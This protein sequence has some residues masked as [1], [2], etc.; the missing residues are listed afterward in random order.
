M[1]TTYRYK[2]PLFAATINLPNIGRVDCDSGGWFSAASGSAQEAALLAAGAVREDEL[3]SLDG[4]GMDGV[5]RKPETYVRSLDTPLPQTTPVASATTT[6]INTIINDADGTGNRMEWPGMH[7][8]NRQR[9]KTGTGFQLYVQTGGVLRLMRSPIGGGTANSVWTEVDRITGLDLFKA[10]ILRDPSRDHLFLVY[11]KGASNSYQIAIRTYDNQG[12]SIAAEFLVDP[13]GTG[14]TADLSSNGA[15][16]ESGCGPSG[17]VVLA[18]WQYPDPSTLRQNTTLNCYKTIQ[19]CQWDGTTWTRKPMEKFYI[20][21]RA[22]YDMLG[23]G[24]DGDTNMAYGVMQFNQGWWEATHPYYNERLPAIRTA[25]TYLFDRIGWWKHNLVTGDFAWGYVTPPLPWAV[26]PWDG[27]GSAFNQTNDAPEARFRTCTFNF[28]T[29]DW[30]V[31][32]RCNRPNPYTAGFTFTGSIT[33]NTLT[34]TTITGTPINEGTVLTAASQNTLGITGWI[35]IRVKTLGANGT[36]GTGGTGTYLL[37]TPCTIASGTISATNPSTPSTTAAATVGFRLAIF[38][39]DGRLKWDGDVL[40][41]LSYGLCN[42]WQHP[43]TGRMF[44]IYTGLGSQRSELHVFPLTQNA[45]GSVNQ[46]VKSAANTLNADNTPVGNVGM[47]QTT[48]YFGTAVKSPARNVSVPLGMTDPLYGA[49]PAEWIDAH[50]IRRPVD[51][52][53]GGGTA[54]VATQTM[55]E[56]LRMLMPLT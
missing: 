38:S 42:I 22:D 5:R 3:T 9:M 46:C 34:V 54:N 26:R 31:P 35:P 30:W 17:Q 48:T 40:P 45:D 12:N 8:G 20:H 23:V 39:P 18:G 28:K 56:H 33:G 52:D 51:I 15:Y 50:V 4:P 6:F 55:V 13:V 32:Y 43:T 2:M 19:W 49:H 25:Q 41:S 37:D 7:R 29:G 47:G 21:Q 14:M 27:D 16:I 11:I 36:T 44:L 24:L 53:S 1:T 10:N